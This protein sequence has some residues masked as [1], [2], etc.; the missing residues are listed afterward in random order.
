MMFGMFDRFA[1]LVIFVMFA[2]TTFIELHLHMPV[3][4]VVNVLTACLTSM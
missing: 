2:M 4:P 3:M 1:M